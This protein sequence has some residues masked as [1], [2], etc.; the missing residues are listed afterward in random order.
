MEQSGY[1]VAIEIG[2]S[3]ISGIV[4]KK[5]SDGNIQVLSYASEQSSSFIKKGMVF[6]IDKTA[7]S[8]TNIVNRLE[9]ETHMTVNK[10]YVGLAGKSMHTLPNSVMRSFDDARSPTR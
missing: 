7:L 6:N 5:N 1:V 2:S 10:V 3:K 9:G 8:L 4:G